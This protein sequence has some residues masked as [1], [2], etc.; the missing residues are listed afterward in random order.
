MFKVSHLLYFIVPASSLITQEMGSW[1]RRVR[2]LG[3]DGVE[4]LVRGPEVTAGH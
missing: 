1:P 4:G 3:A 2:Q